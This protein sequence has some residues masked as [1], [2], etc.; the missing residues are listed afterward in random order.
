MTKSD[1]SRIQSS[2]AKTGDDMSSKGFAA[3][4]LS[5]GDRWANSNS[6]ATNPSHS[7]EASDNRG[8]IESLHLFLPS[9]YR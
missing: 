9:I 3:R 7:S 5:A 1:S 4:A 2:Q 6:T 8:Y